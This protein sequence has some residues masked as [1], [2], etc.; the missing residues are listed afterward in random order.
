MEILADNKKLKL[1]TDGKFI[2][3]LEY[4]GYEVLASYSP[5]FRAGLRGED[6][7]FIEIS[8]ADA[9]NVIYDGNTVKFSGFSVP[10]TVTAEFKNDDKI[11]VNVSIKN[12]SEYAV[13]WVIPL[14]LAVKPLCQDGGAEGTYLLLPYNEGALVDSAAKIPPFPVKYPSYGSYP[15]FPNMMFAQL[16]SY[17]FRS[18]GKNRYINLF[19]PDT[20]RGLK[21]INLRDNELIMRL[22]CGGD[23]GQSINIGYPLVISG[24]D[25]GWEKSA[26]AYKEWFENNLPEGAVKS[27]DNTSLP[28]W[29]DKN[30]IVVSYP[31]RGVHDMDDMKPN[32]LFPYENALPYLDNVYYRT[33][34]RPL[35]LLMHWEGTAPWAPPYVMPPYGEESF[36]S[37]RDELHRRGFML[38]VY[39]S[40]FGFTERSNLI[41]DYDLTERIKNENLLSMMCA[42]P[43]GKVVKSEI[44]PGQRSGYDT[45]PACKKGR[46]ILTEAYT[47]LF[48]AGIDY[49]QI[50]DQN[51][52]GGQ[53]LC[54]SKNHGHAPTP[55]DWMTENM[56]DM[57]AEWKNKAGKMLLGCESAAAE[58]FIPSLPLS[59]NRYELNY[60]LGRPVPLYA[61]LF[62]EYLRNFMGNQ[63]SCPLPPTTDAL[64]YRLAYSFAAGDIPTLIFTPD[65]GISPSWGTRDFSVMPDKDEVLSFLSVCSKAFD[66]GLSPYLTHGKMIIPPDFNCGKADFRQDLPEI[67][68]TAWEY[69]GK[70]T[71]VLINP[72]DKTAECEFDGKKVIID[73]RSVIKI[74]L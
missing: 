24:G 18:D 38:G 21:E 62:H 31:V 27:A 25:G 2:T 32:A 70:K 39:C 61:Y 72:F 48:S 14:P 1:T 22:Y 35:A 23:F 9:E 6:G 11:Y 59:D 20:K 37:F 3:S 29:Y 30:L 40:G 17:L 44:C 53:Y 15:V 68:M 47:P 43:D 64:I 28:E 56:A 8:A 65:G 12:E 74:D 34:M 41:T 67:I 58:P 36:Y 19:T 4:D 51:H 46:E 5:T 66:D 26:E 60:Y 52:G 57:L 55:G 73:N 13:E 63:V 10:V 49:A 50:L 69:E 33:K 42:G 54:Y 45:C 16:A 71:A 7:S